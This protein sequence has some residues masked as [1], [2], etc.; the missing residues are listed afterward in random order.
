[1]VIRMPEKRKYAEPR[2]SVTKMAWRARGVWKSLF[3]AELAETGNVAYAC[4]AAKISRSTV[5]ITRNE[6]AEFAEAWF[7][8]IETNT[9]T[10]EAEAYR[11]GMKGV[12]EPVFYKGDK[13]ADVRKYSDTLLIFMLKSRRPDKFRDNATIVNISNVSPRDITKMSDNELDK[14]IDEHINKRSI[15]VSNS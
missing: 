9:D 14:F 12:D 2:N 7:H 15:S 4:A 8:A 13:V 3:L 6:D 10:M 1:M 11:R 5:Y